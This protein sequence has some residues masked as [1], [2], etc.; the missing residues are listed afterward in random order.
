MDDL[1]YGTRNKRGDWQPHQSLN[2]AP[3]W[4]LP[5]S[6]GK[7]LSWLLSY[8]FGWNL[9]FFASALVW[10]F[11]VLPD[12]ET[13]KTLSAGWIVRLLV[14]NWVAIILFYG[15]FE[16]RFYK[17]QAQDRRFKYNGKFPSEQPSDV[18]WFKSQNID[19][20]IRSILI[21]VP[22]GT[23]VEV[24]ALWAFASGAVPMIALADHPV[25][26]TTLVLMSPIIHE[27]HFFF[28]HRAIHWPPI[29]RLVH[30]V[31]HNSV[32]PSPWSSLSMH[33]VEGFLYFASV[34]WQF[35]LFSNPFLVVFQW[36]LAGFG[37]V[38][39]HIGFDKLEVTPD[40]AIDSHAYAH[41][42]HH[43]H[44][45]VNYCDDGVL[46]WDKWFGTWH[47][48][49]P[50]SEKLMQDRFRKKRERLN[51]KTSATPPQ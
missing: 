26:F 18:F 32:N 8:L 39:G 22:I 46:P 43:K 30:S 33:P 31:H 24:I 38:V 20:F 11:L 28:I 41:Y 35:A 34:F 44:F 5:F 48:G 45:E 2:V 12:V 37:A 21:S 51:R 49:S 14:A 6:G 7:I 50:E 13:M 9:L 36:N 29:Y 1:E 25:W 40:T 3:F 15:I 23:A 27:A 16:W 42:L 17:R 4:R 10:W 47:D 19:N